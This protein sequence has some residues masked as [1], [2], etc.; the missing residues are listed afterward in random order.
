MAAPSGFGVPVGAGHLLNDLSRDRARVNAECLHLV[1]QLA[2]A[3][4]GGAP[5]VAYPG[6]CCGDGRDVLA[7]RLNTAGQ[8]AG[9]GCIEGALRRL[10]LPGEVLAAPLDVVERGAGARPL[11]LSV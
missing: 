11:V 9:R 8:P 10:Q 7:V 1:S 4:R 6:Q 2:L 3:G 5:L